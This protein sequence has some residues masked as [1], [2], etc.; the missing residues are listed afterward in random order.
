MNHRQFM[1][2]RR[3]VRL[4]RRL[5]PAFILVIALIG[6]TACGGGGDRI[7]PGGPNSRIPL[8]DALQ[9]VAPPET[10]QAL[11]R[12]LDLRPQVS[13]TAPEPDAVLQDDQVT[14]RFQVQDFPAFEDEDLGMGPHLHVIVDN[15]PYRA[16]YNP[17]EPLVLEGLEP[18]T[19]TIRAFA[20]RP[21]LRSRS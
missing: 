3:A 8:P 2:P 7:V 1:L 5:Q 21:W 14:V 15:E 6:L 11:S 16:L 9:E 18:G 17:D 10:I 20:S 12:E 19:H 4:F 13:I